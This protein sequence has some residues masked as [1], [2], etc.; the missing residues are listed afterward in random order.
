MSSKYE[1]E[2][3]ENTKLVFSNDIIQACVA[4]IDRIQHEMDN[5]IHLLLIGFI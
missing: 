3:G 4:T 1:E 2:N 5:K